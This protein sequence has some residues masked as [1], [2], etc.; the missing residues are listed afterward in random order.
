MFG[1][2]LY[3]DT[4]FLLSG[5]VS[6]NNDG[7]FYFSNGVTPTEKVVMLKLDT[8]MEGHGRLIY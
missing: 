3:G 2:D 1:A 7:K 5:T 6:V 8:K 4:Y